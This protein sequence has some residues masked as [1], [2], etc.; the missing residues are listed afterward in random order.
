MAA[1]NEEHPQRQRACHTTLSLPSI[2]WHTGSAAGDQDGLVYEHVRRKHRDR[3]NPRRRRHHADGPPTGWAVAPGRS[4]CLAHNADAGAPK[5]RTTRLAAP[6]SW[7]K[8][9]SRPGWRL[10]A[11]QRG[12]N[13][14]GHVLY[15]LDD[16]QRFWAAC[17][18]ALRPDGKV[19]VTTATRPGSCRSSG[20]ACATHPGHAS[21]L[22]A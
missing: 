14:A 18:R 20:R 21:S 2:L 3:R 17:L 1:R 22:P 12:P 4:R 6:P 9:R 13:R 10:R 19:V 11:C 15:A 16:R 5:T 8:H 7:C